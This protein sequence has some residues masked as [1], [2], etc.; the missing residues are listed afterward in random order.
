MNSNFLLLYLYLD[1]KLDHTG[2]ISQETLF[3]K[4]H[5]EISAMHLHI[6]LF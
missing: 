2:Y 3:T 6:F 1:I 4:I 5:T